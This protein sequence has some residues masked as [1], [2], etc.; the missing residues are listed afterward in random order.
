MWRQRPS[1]PVSAT[2]L[3]DG[4]IKLNTGVSLQKKLAHWKSSFI[5]GRKWNF[6]CILYIFYLIWIE[7]GTENVRKNL[8][9]AESFIRIG[10]VTA[11]RYLKGGG[12]KYF[13][14]RTFNNLFP[15]L[16]KFRTRDLN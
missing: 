13:S 2:E 6:T 10:P 16:V 5:G 14:I 4:F 15:I 8:V 1:T 7:V 12:R 9:N 11:V 3:F